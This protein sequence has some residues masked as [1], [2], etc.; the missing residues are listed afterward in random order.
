LMDAGVGVR[1]VECGTLVP[2]CSSPT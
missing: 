2:R 1:H